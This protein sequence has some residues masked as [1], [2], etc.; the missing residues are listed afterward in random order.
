MEAKVNAKLD[1]K[2]IKEGEMLTALLPGEFGA[3][4]E[5]IVTDKEGNITEKRVMK[6]E[7][8]VRQFMELLYITVTSPYTDNTYP[9][10]DTGNAVRNCRKN[11]GSSYTPFRCDAGAG[12]ITNGI[13][14]GT[15]VVAPTINDY[16]LGTKINHGIGAGQLQYSNMAIA[17]P[18]I[19]GFIS[20]LTLTRDF[21][22][23]PAGA[24]T[25]N[26]IGIY[27]QFRDATATTR[28]FMVIRDTIVGGIAVPAGVTLTINYRIQATA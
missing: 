14:V 10:R 8:F 22:N 13:V 5:L 11:V 20:Q 21:S 3:I 17:Y 19:N 28:Y 15:G 16:A 6:S 4:L 9:V 26:E 7:S 25:V 18:A 23:G 12:V 27:V 1:V 2:V 24:V